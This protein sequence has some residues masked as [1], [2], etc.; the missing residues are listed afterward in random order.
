MVALLASLVF[1]WQD[2]SQMDPALITPCMRRFLPKKH[3]QVIDLEE[4]FRRKAQADVEAETACLNKEI[5]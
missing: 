2:V 1:G 4:M 5:N 3:Y